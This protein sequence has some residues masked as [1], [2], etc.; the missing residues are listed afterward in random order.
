MR[1][2]LIRGLLNL[3]P[4]PFRDRYGAEITELL[5]RSARPWRD[6]VN[7]G[8]CALTERAAAGT[9]AGARSQLWRLGWL[10][11]APLGFGIAAVIVALGPM[12]LASALEDPFGYHPAATAVNV[13]MAM[14]ILPVCL[15]A[16]WLARR[17]A[18]RRGI[19][20]PIVTVPAGL[21]LGIVGLAGLPIAGEM[22]GATFPAT[23]VAAAF[24]CAAML[25]VGTA[26]TAL[27]RR[28]RSHLAVLVLVAGGLAALELAGASYVIAAGQDGRD[29]AVALGLWPRAV[30]GAG[31]S[32]GT[33]ADGV[34]YLP[35]M[36]TMCTT[37]ALT[38]IGTGA[39]RGRPADA[40]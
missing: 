27:I 38:L 4:A 29:W 26:G 3:Y 28:K 18:R 25:A 23:V 19:A 8:W 34:N 11:A 36:L 10:V 2:T 7:V 39:G 6:L 15:E 40:G 16:V 14:S 20:A 22:L 35:A 5:T 30:S 13:V 33:N 12:T 24:W 21:T 32:S 9:W 17:M 1:A 37:F 31:P